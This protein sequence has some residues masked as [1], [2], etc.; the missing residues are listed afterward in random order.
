MSRIPLSLS[1]FLFSLAARAA[2]SPNFEQAVTGL[3]ARHGGRIGI[4]AL[5]TGGGRHIEHRANERFLM[6][7]TFKLLAAAAVLH[8]VDQKQ[9]RLDR[10]VPYSA[11]DLLEY[12]PVT[13]QHVNEGGMSLGALCHAAI[14]V[15]DNTAGNLL[16]KSIGGPAGL[17]RYVR[18]LGDEMTR[19]DRMEPDL[20]AAPP[21]DPRDSTTP[22]AML[23]DLR[24]LLLG[25]ALSDESRRQLNEWMNRNETGAGMIRAGVP[26]TWQVGDKTGR[27]ANG[28]TNDIAILRPPNGSPVLLAIYSAG[29][30]APGD[31]RTAIIADVTRLVIQALS[32]QEGGE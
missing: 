21:G 22:T 13:K 5:D 16:L 25:H 15:S 24:T 20:N 17:T 23:N 28:V 14:T 26:S 6:C 19:L 12:A 31:A 9:D 11:S 32:R 2:P 10:F 8:R 18:S 3:E 7:S 1:L 27:G 29:L 30:D 4:A